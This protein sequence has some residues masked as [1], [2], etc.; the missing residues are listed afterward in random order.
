MVC[1]ENFFCFEKDDKEKLNTQ[2]QNTLVR[3]MVTSLE[4]KKLS[5]NA[6]VRIEAFW[7]A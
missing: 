5:W 6:V 4:S 3:N 7:S 1:I 2:K